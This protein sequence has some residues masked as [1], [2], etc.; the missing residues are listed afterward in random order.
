MNRIVWSVG[1]TGVVLSC[2]ALGWL[3]RPVEVSADAIPTPPSVTHPTPVEP[4][5]HPVAVARPATVREAAPAEPLAELEPPPEALLDAAL[6]VQGPPQPE[7]RDR[8]RRALPDTRV[9]LVKAL[10][11]DHASPQARRDAVLAELTASGDSAEP[12]TQDARAA[13]DSWHERIS[14]D[15][16]PV[17]AEAPHCYAAGCVS[18]VTFP[19]EAS[20]RDAWERASGL[21]PSAHSAHLQLPPERLPSGE[22]R[23]PWLVLRPDRS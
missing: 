13:L 6:K 20:F 1:G 11:A 23:V 17:Q 15:V 9:R 19:D 4:S 12:W 2:L 21:S 5:P 18:R 3:Q 14:R 8:A 10:R 16:R 22:V 7:L